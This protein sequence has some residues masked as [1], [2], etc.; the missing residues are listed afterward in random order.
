MKGDTAAVR[1]LLAA[2]ADVNAPQV[3]GATALHW[4][5][6][7]DDVALAQLLID[8]GADAN[9]ANRAGA[10]PLFMAALYGDPAMIDTLLK[11]GADAARL[12]PNGETTVMFAARNGNPD[13]IKLL[14]S[15][16]G[17]VNAREG[18]RATTALM[19]AAEQERPEAV[20]ALVE[21]GADVAAQSGPAGLPRNYLA[22]RVNV[23]QVSKD[24][25]RRRRA[26]AAGRTYEEQVAWERAQGLRIASGAASLPRTEGAPV[27]DEPAV[28][29]DQGA[30]LAGDRQRPVPY[31]TAVRNDVDTNNQDDTEAVIAGLV[32]GGSGELTAL[33]FAAREGNLASAKALIEGGADVNQIT[34][35]GWTPLLIATNNR[36]YRLGALLLKHGADPNIANKGGWTPLYL[37]TDN[38]NIEG[39]DYPV[40]VPDMD[41]IEYIKLLLDHGAD[42]N[43][44]VKEN[45]LTRTIFTMQWFFEPGATAFVRAAQSSD[46]TL[47]KLLL[48]HGADPRVETYYHD[49]ALTVAAGIGW[50]DGVTYERSQA[51]NMEAVRMLVE[52]LGLDVNAANH[53]GR[54]ALMGAAAKGSTEIV[55]YLVDHGAQLDQRDRGS[56]DSRSDGPL[57]GR[58]WNA[59]D[60]ADGL[61]RFGT[62]SAIERVETATL[63]RKMM[64]ERGMFV[65][66]RNRTIE[67]ICVIEKC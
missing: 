30:G 20:K 32:G 10:T 12:G 48:D 49:T 47:M 60:Y 27:P 4:A 26:E 29:A 11:G 31:G 23:D 13:V 2:N 52:D 41:D 46:V 33:S 57:A 62:Q 56:K 36:N 5:V 21:L 37:A 6:H 58:T 9:V 54:T 25:E 40:P 61:V 8:A 67:T 38:R 15:A 16:G 3:D 64:S 7:R 18:I 14:V 19:W 44:Q 63:I 59:L 45:T 17:D 22:L 55:Q 39:G 43:A 34:E 28:G 50:V 35:Y 24:Q 66:P 51:E 42:V 53:D 65:P 1:T